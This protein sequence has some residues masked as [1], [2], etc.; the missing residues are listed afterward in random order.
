MPRMRI[1]ADS[2]DQFTDPGNSQDTTTVHAGQVIDATDKEAERLVGLDAAVHVTDD[3]GDTGP[4]E[5]QLELLED[6]HKRMVSEHRALE[7]SGAAERV[8]SLSAG[9]LA[10]LVRE[11]A[12]ARERAG[13]P[14]QA[15]SSASFVKPAAHRSAKA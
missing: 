2:Y 7:K 3:D 14:S 13:K 1:T 15:G 4:A 10:G 12:K 8:V 5:G 11:V 9:R 6:Q